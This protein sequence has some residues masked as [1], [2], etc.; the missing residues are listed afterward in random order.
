MA[1]PSKYSQKLADDIC[2][3]L[4]DGKSLREICQQ[5]GMPDRKTV[6]RWIDA[7]SGFAAKCA[8]AREEQAEFHHAEMDVIERKVLAGQLDPKAANV[9][10]SNKRWRMEKLKPKVYGQRLALDHGVQDNLAERLK[11][12]RERAASRES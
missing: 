12:A 11:A 10:L 1:R 2:E 4:A 8:R 3:Q 5:K 6:E 7:D 9:V